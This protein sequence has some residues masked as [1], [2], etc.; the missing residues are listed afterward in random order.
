M[1]KIFIND[2]E[3]YQLSA[4]QRVKEW[5]SWADQEARNQAQGSPEVEPSVYWALTSHIHSYMNDLPAQLFNGLR[6]H[7]YHL[8]G[9]TF[10]GAVNGYSGGG[11]IDSA[12]DLYILYA[13]R[14]RSQILE[15]YWIGAP[16]PAASMAVS[17]IGF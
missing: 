4:I 13:A 10:R 12:P 16:M 9:D 1:F 11:A 14:L 3:S 8:D 2:L 7:T 6:L 17:M 5:A 15:R